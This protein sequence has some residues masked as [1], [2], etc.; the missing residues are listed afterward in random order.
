MTVLK[1]SKGLGILLLS[2]KEILVPLLIEFLVLLDVGLFALFSLLGLVEDQLLVSTV[3]V[4]LLELRD[5]VLGH[6]GLDVL[7]LTLTGV[8]VV[9]KHLTTSTKKKKIETPPF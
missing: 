9:F 2:L 4:L 7:A 5:P 6:L 1:L 3:V 8:S